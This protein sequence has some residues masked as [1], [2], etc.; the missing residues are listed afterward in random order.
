[1]GNRRKRQ[2]HEKIEKSKLERSKRQKK[3]KVVVKRY[4]SGQSILILG[5]GDFSFSEGLGVHCGESWSHICATSLDSR[6]TVIQKYGQEA[7]RR[8]EMLES[9]G[10]RL[11]FGIDATDIRRTLGNAADRFDRVI[12][13]FP[14]SGK[15]RVHVNRELIRK[16]FVSCRQVVKPLRGEV[17]LTL[18]DAMPYN[19]WGSKA[20]A[21]ESGFCSIG[22]FPFIP[23]QFPG[24]HHRTTDPTA[25]TFDERGC[26]TTRYVID[27]RIIKEEMNRKKMAKLVMKDDDDDDESAKNK[28]TATTTTK[29][30]IKSPA[31]A[32]RQRSR[33]G[34]FGNMLSCVVCRKSFKK[35]V[36]LLQHLETKKDSAHE[37]YRNQQKESAP[38]PV[39]QTYNMRDVTPS[40]DMIIKKYLDSPH[41]KS[42]NEL[43]KVLVERF[44]IAMTVKKIVCLENGEWLNDEVMNFY[45]KL[46][47]ERSDKAGCMNIHIHNTFFFSKLTENDSYQYGN[48]RRWTR[49]IDLFEKDVVIIPVNYENIHWALAVAYMKSKHLVVLDSRKNSSRC[50]STLKCLRKYFLD[51]YLDKKKI[52]DPKGEESWSF[53][54]I[55]SIPRQKNNYD[56]GVF[57]CVYALCVASGIGL[58]FSQQDI[59]LFRK[60]MCLSIL[61]EC[62]HETFRSGS[63]P[64]MMLPFDVDNKFIGGARVKF[65][66]EV[67]LDGDEKLYEDEKL[68]GDVVVIDDEEMGKEDEDEKKEDT[69]DKNR[70][71]KKRMKKAYPHT[72]K[73]YLA[74]H[75][76]R[77]IRLLRR[78][79]KSLV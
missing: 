13:N 18:K 46:I 48:V 30:T 7:K 54:S 43:R 5:D 1:M 44:K 47:Q 23:R 8:L 57:T 55:K 20:S 32:T 45:L 66:S 63:F 26:R 51:E 59:P 67:K 58:N 33:S 27:P 64:F 75:L 74:L 35:E 4:E 36:S 77:A 79:E 50:M 68:N 78:R 31:T 37:T 60:H 17:H 41:T 25:E 28:K 53:V 40:E 71:K 65:N 73:L 29:T 56:C 3:R 52:K 70:K 12:F 69:S 11:R 24:Y 62:I 61:N 14:H 6:R 22:D 9:R 19:S 76:L 42:S 39:S 49:K 15:Q 21:S 10:A 2:R 38:S 34:S 16:F 72:K